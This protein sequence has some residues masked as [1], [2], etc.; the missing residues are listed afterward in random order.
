MTKIVSN[1]QKLLTLMTKDSTKKSSQ[2]WQSQTSHL[3][4]ETYD[5]E[6]HNKTKNLLLYLIDH[7]VKLYCQNRKSYCQNQT[8][9]TVDLTY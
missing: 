6:S 7:N 4:T 1:R 2:I 8:T 3:I 9:D 5:G